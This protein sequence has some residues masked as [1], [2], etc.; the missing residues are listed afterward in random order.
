VIEG[1]DS[2]ARMVAEAKDE[3]AGNGE[4]GDEDGDGGGDGDG[5]GDGESIQTFGAMMSLL[6]YGKGNF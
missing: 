6:G 4:D 3:C 1:E 2:K 5:D